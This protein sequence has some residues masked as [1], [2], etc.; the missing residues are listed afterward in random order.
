[1]ADRA[2]LR[3]RLEERLS[4]LEAEFDT[5][6]KMLAELEARQA[7]LRETLLRLVGA[8]T[9]LKEELA[10]SDGQPAEGSV[11]ERAG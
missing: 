11:S 2:S 10:A 6:Q 5:G 7:S 3:Q 4:A 8:I 9:V 1:V